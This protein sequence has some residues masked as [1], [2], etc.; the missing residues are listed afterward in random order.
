MPANKP[1]STAAKA[2]EKAAAA[3]AQIQIFKPGK[4][5]S[6][7]GQ[8]LEFSEADL[9]ATCAAYDPTLHEAPLVVGHPQHDLPAYGWVKSLALCDGAIDAT[10]AQVNPDFADMVA[11][12]AYK[13]ISAAFYSPDAPSNPVPGVYYLRHVGFLGAQAPAIKG[14]RSPEFSDTEEGVVTFSEWDDTDNAALWRN[15]REWILA[16]FGAAEADRA[17]PGYTVKSL[18]QG[19]QD[20]LRELQ[21]PNTSQSGAATSTAFGEH[22]THTTVNK[23]MS[24]TPEEIAAQT[25]ALNAAQAE[26]AALREQMATQKRVTV[27]ATNMAFC[28]AL[29]AKATLAPAHAPAVV[30]VL[31]HLD[32]QDTPIEFG[33]GDARAPLSKGLR[34]LLQ[35]LPPVVSFGEHA[36][37]GAAAAAAGG[38]GGGTVAFAAPSDYTVDPMAAARHSK[39]LAYQAQ[40]QCDYLAAVRATA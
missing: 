9:A 34:D 1:T 30:A 24:M 8:A 25:A 23:E 35:A 6:M 21:A 27:H 32:L 28:E 17:V 14:L 31:D 2:A 26:T 18:E 36:T 11:A 7:S 40:H 12:G 10:P 16:K 22:L 20:G 19:A 37:T 33:E 15:M 4:H 13:K 5:V 38:A 3:P 29:T 39:A